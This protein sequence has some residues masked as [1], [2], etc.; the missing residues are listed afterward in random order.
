MNRRPRFVALAALSVFL[1]A[2][3][4]AQTNTGTITGRIFDSAKALLPGA[5]VTIT[6]LDTNVATVVN[7]TDQGNYSAAGLLPGR[8]RVT[9]E[10]E[11]FSKAV[12][13][14]VEVFTAS[15]T[16]ADITMQIGSVTESITV[17][18]EAPLLSADSA[19]VNTTV[20]NQ[21]IQEIP[22]PERSSLGAVMLSAGIQGD[23]Q[24]PGGIQ[25]ENAG[26]YT[27]PLAPGG[28]IA[29]GG[30]R[31]GSGS[32]LVDGSDISL[33]SY[34][35]TGVT[36][37]GNTVSQMSVQANGI[38]AQYGRTS[39]GVINQTTKGGTNQLHGSASWQHT[40]PG[41]QAWK[42]GTHQ[43]GVPPMFKQNMFGASIG[44]PVVLPK[45]YNG[46]N[47]TFF[48]ATV[49]PS[50]LSDLVYTGLGRIPTPDELKGD[51]AYGWDVLNRC[52]NATLRSKGV[53]AAMAELRGLYASGSAP[54]LYYQYDRNADGF[55]IGDRYTDRNLYV[56]IPNNN[57]SAQLAKNPIAKNLLSYYPTPSKPSPYAVFI[58]PDGLW[59]ANGNNA[60]LARGV[61]NT[62]DR[63]SFRID[64]S[65]T[66]GNRVAFRYTYVPVNG[67]RFNFLGPDSEA[68]P[69]A[70]D[71]S[72]ARNFYLGHTQLLGGNKV[73]EFR[74][75][76][77]R[78]NQLRYASELAATKDFGAELG[79]RPA[80][81]GYGFPAFTGLPGSTLGSGGT[82][83]NGNGTTLDVNLGIADDFSWVRGTHNFKFGMDIRA[84]QMNRYDRNE[85]GGGTYNFNAS[86][87]NDGTGGGS[88]L[89]SFILGIVNQYTVRTVPMAFYYR[90]KYYA[91]Y[92]QDDW[93]VTPKLTL[94]LG[95]RYSVEMPRMEKYDRQGS[96]DSNVTGTLNGVPV[97]GGF[98]FSGANG[99]PRGLWRTNWMGF[100]PRVGFAYTPAR[101]VSTR[102]SFAL[103]RA[104]LTGQSFFIVP[105][106]NVQTTPISGN[107][108]GVRPGQVNLVTNPVGQIPPN[109]PLSGGPL[110]S[111]T[112]TGTAAL[113]YINPADDQPYALQ[114]SYSMQYALT[115]NSIVE[116]TYSGNKGNHLF[117]PSVDQNIPPYQATKDAIKNQVN[118]AQQVNNPF[119]I[120]DLSGRPLQ[121]GV[122]DL[123]R[124]FPHLWS[125]QISSMFDRRGS[126]IY[127][128]LWLSFKHRFSKGL[129]LQ[130][131]FTWAK[132]I[133][134]ASASF[135][136]LIGQETD[137]FGLARAQNPTNL[138]AERSESTFSIPHKF[139]MA[140]NYELPIGKGRSFPVNNSLIN[141]MFGG[142]SI[143]GLF[144]IQDGYPIWLRQGS[145]G[146]WF[147]QAGGG[148]NLAS[149]AVL[150]PN[151][152]PGV[153][154]VNPDWRKNP[155]I[156]GSF[157]NSN[158]FAVPG[159]LDN[160]A[161]GNLPRT[162][163]WARN[164]VTR[165]L[166]A[167]LSKRFTL[168][169]REKLSLTLRADF[170]NVLNHPNF[171]FNPNTGHDWLGGD[172]NRQSLTNPAI[173]AFT[174]NGSFGKM[175]PNNTNNGRTIRVTIRLSF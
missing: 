51:L 156:A 46:R 165:T 81:Q 38:P 79:L 42:H 35:R 76:Y 60:F 143:A 140:Y 145:G 75:T 52:C 131:S 109:Q 85:L 5:K 173:Q 161:F 144:S 67:T 70:R 133:D 129:T 19:A 6:N 24:Y 39:G 90:W 155:Y 10:K 96:F 20:E 50:R 125:Q 172:F 82:L 29:I 28:S 108:G 174:I 69:V 89:A 137:I 36:F 128:A 164:P 56:P 34:P 163:S 119:G 175:D 98:V 43:A 59:D 116:A 21:L 134:D 1:C 33:A 3:C 97:K 103:L 110:F 159:S 62:D 139:T 99:H 162:M 152:V 8:Y 147:S 111:W 83:G 87:T 45:A 95:L 72:S 169:P 23:P 150:R 170:L 88:A 7:A 105:D 135:G 68:N 14:A 61:K 47:R 142:W 141:G 121:M 149:G 158:A 93:K 9:V 32:I 160:P 171:F 16:T 153:P 49:E 41:L 104:P 22:F 115:Q 73:N 86:Q 157:L 17:R 71:K 127:H 122:F 120:V 112:G 94:N 37:S 2:Q 58:R 117:S 126:S 57:L 136:G 124:P 55:P 31:P 102:A 65:L 114:W 84:F 151:L 146:Y 15:V 118:F 130:G 154:V 26:I 25:S 54:Q 66:S 113:P 92:F 63:Y 100:E 91:G 107:S 101:R 106:L 4:L 18:E 80:T 166:D 167:N 30:G 11:G 64:H 77:M 123:A 44:G 27:P 74:L 53:E 132:S 12:V 48:Y 40:D 138:K 148:G 78:A 13:E 168:P